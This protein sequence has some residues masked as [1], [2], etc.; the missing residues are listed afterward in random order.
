MLFSVIRPEF[1]IM[2]FLK[3]GTLLQTKKL[4]DFFSHEH[5][6]KQ[7]LRYRGVQ[8]GGHGLQNF[9]AVA[10]VNLY[11]L[12]CQYF[13]ISD[14]Y[15]MPLYW[16]YLIHSLPFI[17]LGSSLGLLLKVCTFQP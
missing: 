12:L 11:S 15:S 2:Q 4:F 1:L 3:G 9:S 14:R 8:G 10:T 13:R 5:K 16:V 17:S 7:G 6:S